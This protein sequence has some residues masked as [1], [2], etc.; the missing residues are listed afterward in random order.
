MKGGYVIFSRDVLDQMLD[1]MSQRN[2]ACTPI[3]CCT[4]PNNKSCLNTLFDKCAHPASIASWE[5]LEKVHPQDHLNRILS[6]RVYLYSVFDEDIPVGGERVVTM[7]DERAFITPARYRAGAMINAARRAYETGDVLIVPNTGMHHASPR[8]AEGF[9]LFC[10]VPLSWIMLRELYPNI[11]ALYIDVDVHHANGTALARHELGITE[12]FQMIDMFNEEIWPF[13][14]GGP[15]A[16]VEHVSIPV[17]YG[18]GINNTS[19]LSL[20]KGA[21]QRAS[22]EF[23]RPDLIYY[24]CSND[25]LVGDPLGHVNVTE[26]GLYA[27]DQM[28]MEWARTRAIPIILMP[29]RGY[30]AA[31]CRVTRESMQRLNDKY[32]LF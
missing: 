20:L 15:D 31:S 24:M 27:R 12:H 1:R 5:E 9:G 2:G 19:F 30:G 8:K 13:V 28:V 16:A 14:E 26:R 17:P 3:N 32:N 4:D 18:C 29:S 21:L 25:A 11:T 23:P 22:E 7:E 6:D 10:D